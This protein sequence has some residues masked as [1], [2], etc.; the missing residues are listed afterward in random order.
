M[1]GNANAQE[2]EPPTHHVWLKCCT[3]LWI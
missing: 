3:G 1:G 2:E